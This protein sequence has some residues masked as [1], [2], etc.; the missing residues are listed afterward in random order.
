M[1]RSAK[2]ES[3]QV[4]GVDPLT[5]RKFWSHINA[6]VERGVTVMVT[7][8]FMDEAEYCDRIGLVDRGRLIAEG[9]P[10]EMKD[11]VRNAERPDPTME[12]AFIAIV[13]EFDR[14]AGRT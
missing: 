12:D 5:R 2:R 10:D 11:R 1:V 7:T 9:S 3:C 6:Q 8:H 14:G 4:A 13:E